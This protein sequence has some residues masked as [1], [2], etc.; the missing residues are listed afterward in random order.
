MLRDGRDSGLVD[1]MVGTAALL[2][3]GF[4][5]LSRFFAGYVSC[6]ANGL[7]ISSKPS[8]GLSSVTVG[9]RRTTSPRDLVVCPISS[10]GQRCGDVGTTVDEPDCSSST[11]S[12]STRLRSWSKPLRTPVTSGLSAWEHER[13]EGQ[14]TFS[15]A[16]KLDPYPLVDVL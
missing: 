1:E 9:P 2:M 13:V 14:R 12:S 11:T 8:T 16:S 5:Q 15:A 3:G 7:A 6:A 4:V 10:E